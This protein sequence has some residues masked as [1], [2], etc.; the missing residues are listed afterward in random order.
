MSPMREGCFIRYSPIRDLLFVGLDEL[1]AIFLRIYFR[2]LAECGTE[3][4]K[5]DST[6]FLNHISNASQ[7]ASPFA[8]H[9]AITPS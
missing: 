9:H 2:I 8:F 3:Q 4:A 1:S 6:P 7:V 5:V